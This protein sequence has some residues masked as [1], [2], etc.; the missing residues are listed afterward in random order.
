M[1]DWAKLKPQEQLP[2]TL[3][4]LKETDREELRLLEGMLAV[5]AKLMP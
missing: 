3:R 5:M 2:K 4:F 1:S